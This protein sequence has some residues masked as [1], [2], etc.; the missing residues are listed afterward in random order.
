VAKEGYNF[1]MNCIECKTA[2]PDGNS[3]CGK[4]GAELG[5]TLDETVRKKNFR[6][7]QATEIE[8]TEAVAERLSRW[9]KW[10]AVAT[11]VPITLFAVLLGW[12][13]HD[14]RHSVEQAKAEMAKA[15]DG[16]RKD[17]AI[18]RKQVES[19]QVDATALGEGV[20]QSKT[21]VQKYQ[22]VN[23]E[24]ERLQKQILEVKGQVVDLGKVDLKVHKL[25]V[26]GSGEANSISWDS[27]TGCP[28][29]ALAKGS[30]VAICAQ[31]SPPLIYER[32]VSG[33]RPVA[34]LSP[35]GFQ[36]ASL[37][38][39]KPGCTET[40]RGT[41]YVEK[42]TGKT[43]DKPLVCVRQSDNSYAWVDLAR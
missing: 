42:G 40:S 9:A 32:N 7:R 20:K 28:P 10:L 12:T 17:I 14:I 31:D 5:R 6:D 16:A 27:R 35:I 19:V 11:G 3:Y 13:F 23:K 41:F 4:C 37:P 30:T 38:G 21:D 22:L 36:D 33:A 34:S 43:A 29:S 1:R 39:S 15:I 2:N 25:E 24:I 26:L 8:I 18:I